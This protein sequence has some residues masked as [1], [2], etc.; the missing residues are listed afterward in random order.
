MPVQKFRSRHIPV[1]AIQYDGKNQEEVIEF[2]GKRIVKSQIPFKSNP[3][4]LLDGRYSSLISVGDWVVRG[5][6]GSYTIVQSE[7]FPVAFEPYL[8]K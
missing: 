5:E 1:E 3:L 2:G 8:G 4:Y 7:D 6:M